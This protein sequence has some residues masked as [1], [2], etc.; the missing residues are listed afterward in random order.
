[1]TT[2]AKNATE[3]GFTLIEVLVSLV[4]MGIIVAA[5]L[6]TLW[7][8]M[9][10]WERGAAV[11]DSLQQDRAL[12]ERLH[13]ELKSSFHAHRPGRSGLVSKEG[14]G[15]RTGEE[16]LIF[17][18]SAGSWPGLSIVRYRAGKS[19]DGEE[20]LLRSEIPM[21]LKLDFDEI[22]EELDD[23]ELLALPGIAEVNASFSDGEDWTDEWD[24]E[25]VE[26]DVPAAVRLDFKEEKDGSERFLPPVIVSLRAQSEKEGP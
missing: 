5:V 21:P 2:V 24:P 3:A 14:K 19:E 12:M 16:G 25:G 22:V 7:T 4:M 1:M 8:G 11:S 20:G 6:G 17:V 18:T 26:E 13:M 15:S 23:V 9:G 10:S